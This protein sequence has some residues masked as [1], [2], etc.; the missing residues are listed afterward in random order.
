MGHSTGVAAPQCLRALEDANRV[1]VARAQLKRRVKAGGL[2][3]GEVILT[4]PWQVRTMS[5]I[6]L[7][8]SQRSWG[9]IRSRRL[10]LSLGLAEN[11]PVGTLTERQRL[12]LA[13]QLRP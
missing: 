1:R 10:L 6:D 2:T 11:K 12:A 13:A 3:A 9:R 7:L 4:C 5:V 8:G